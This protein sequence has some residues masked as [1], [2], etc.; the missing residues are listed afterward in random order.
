M[1][2]SAE[3]AG[4]AR[5]Q[6]NCS[7]E[8]LLTAKLLVFFVAF[9][10]WFPWLT[11]QRDVG[12]VLVFWGGS[13]V[14][15]VWILEPYDFL[16]FFWGGRSQKCKPN[17]V[18]AE[19]QPPQKG[20]AV[21]QAG[22]LHPEDESEIQQAICAPCNVDSDLLIP[23]ALCFRA[24]RLLE[25]CLSTIR[26]KMHSSKMWLGTFFTIDYIGAQSK[27]KQVTYPFSHHHF[28]HRKELF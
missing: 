27:D 26:I 1:I 20:V 19:L 18:L 21:W 15:D 14:K 8:K 6:S 23:T 3:A 12:K 17:H 7:G 2:S 11:V 9:I 13:I 10:S 16:Y 25:E 22:N 5:M 4:S 24:R 28:F